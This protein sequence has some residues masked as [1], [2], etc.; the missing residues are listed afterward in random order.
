MFDNTKLKKRIIEKYET[1]SAFAKIT[2]TPRSNLSRYLSGKTDLDIET[3]NKWIDLL[4]IPEEEIDAYFFTSTP[5]PNL[6]AKSRF[7]TSKLR[8][9]ILGIFGTY[10]NFAQVLDVSPDLVCSRLKGKTQ[11]TLDEISSWS[12]I[13]KIDPTEI[14]DYFFR[15]DR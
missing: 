9:R 8:S 3:M 13:L 15:K 1:Q 5:E 6:K 10:K 4:E 2:N 7:D 12:K 11:F 14:D